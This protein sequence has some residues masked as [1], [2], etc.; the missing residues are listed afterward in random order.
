MLGHDLMKALSPS[1]EAEGADI[2]D[3]DITDREATG[4]FI[5]ARRPSAVINAAARTDVDACER[6]R[7]G[8]FAVNARGAEN[9][10][11]ACAA[12]GARLIHLSTDYVFD[13]RARSPYREN[14]PTC[15][16]SVYG[17][18]KRAGEEAVARAI[19]DCI[20][21]RTSWLFGLHG[22][23][24]IDTILKAAASPRALEVVGD[25]RGA[26]TYSGDCAGAIAGL[27]ATAYRGVVHFTN[28]GD[29][30]WYEYAL[31][32]L[33]IAGVRGVRVEEITSDRL[34]RPAPRPAYSVLD[35]S[36]Y[37][38]LTGAAR[39]HWRDAAR[40]YISLVGRR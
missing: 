7:D 14:D 20:I 19:N 33:E 16:G 35:C 36:L 34:S 29:C 13:G 22:K 30:S 27:L 4:S 26:P 37:E 10:A 28:S 40:E 3:L 24:F 12:A 21:V 38:R 1:R 32:I 2:G 9:V 31:A 11:A 8:A 18:S 15:P 17:A 6:D 25:Q 39:R 23:N 5:L